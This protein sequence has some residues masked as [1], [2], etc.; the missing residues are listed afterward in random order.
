MKL[1]PLEKVGSFIKEDYVLRVMTDCK[2]GVFV[3][4][5][6]PQVKIELSTEHSIII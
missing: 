1:L 3:G 4:G 5:V 6:I 2:R